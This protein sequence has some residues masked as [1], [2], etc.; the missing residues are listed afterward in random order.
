MNSNLEF[1]KNLQ[2]TYMDFLPYILKI[3]FLGISTFYI[4]TKIINNKNFFNLKLIFVSIFIF[5]ISI[6]SSIL[7]YNLNFTIEMTALILM[8][9]ISYSIATKNKFK[10]SS[11]ITIISFSINYITFIIAIFINFL[12]NVLFN[13]QNDYI[14]LFCIILV[15]LIIMHLVFKIPKLKYGFS[16]L[17]DSAKSDFFE[18]F[19]FNISIT[20]I[21]ISLAF[22]TPDYFLSQKLLFAFLF[23]CVIMFITI[24]KSFEIYYKHNLLIK[25]LQEAKE[26]IN[27]KDKEIIKLENE[28][29]NFSKT[30]HSIAHRQKSLE[31]K[32]NELLLKNETAS[33]LDIKDSINEI[34]KIYLSRTPISPL[35]KTNIIELD[36]MLKFM[37]SE[38]IKYNIDF[39]LQLYGNIYHMINNVIDKESLEILLA[40]L[41][42]NSIIA[43][44]YSDNINRSILVKLG[45]IDDYYSLYVYDSGIEFDINTL[46][47]LGKKPCSTH[48]DSGGSGI[49]FMNIFDILKKY[50]ASITINELNSP[51]KD[52]YTKVIMIKFNNQKIF[53]ISSYRSK[54]IKDKLTLTN[55]LIE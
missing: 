52:N 15:H 38:C 23:L 22:N 34:S 54:Q 16:F 44:N 36:D 39:E 2:N 43:V 46:L 10:Y 40:D 21:F 5:I 12:P 30:S 32:L 55:F 20:L 13:L 47:T 42:K 29:L 49:G 9:S 48:I 31:F 7:K 27:Q 33:E 35:S 8:L 24:K 37:Q 17:K 4:F 45:I 18:V 3:F 19:I 26:T 51:S 41:I 25:E 50:N 6:L 14:R 11:I 53:K 1:I 28:N